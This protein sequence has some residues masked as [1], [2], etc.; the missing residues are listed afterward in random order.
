MRNCQLEWEVCCL[1]YMWVLRLSSWVTYFFLAE[2][3]KLDK[4]TSSIQMSKWS[5]IVYVVWKSEIIIIWNTFPK[6]QFQNIIYEFRTRR[7]F[8]SL[9][10][11]RCVARQSRACR[12][13]LNSY[14][15]LTD[16][17]SSNNLPSVASWTE[18][19]SM[20]NEPYFFCA[21]VQFRSARQKHNLWTGPKTFHWRYSQ[22]MRHVLPPLLLMFYLTH[23]IF[24]LPVIVG[25]ILCFNQQSFLCPTAA[26][27]MI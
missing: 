22:F 7:R 4:R 15:G 24:F 5:W 25:T 11:Q 23:Y 8:E 3:Q 10:H 13:L 18:L 9:P 1:P 6:I 14:L 19:K 27:G 17:C 16:I 2:L 26:S 12:T 21:F 20:I